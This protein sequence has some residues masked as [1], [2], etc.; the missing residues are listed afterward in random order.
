MKYKF[1]INYV[2]YE[3]QG[4]VEIKEIRFEK[5]EIVEIENDTVWGSE[6]RTVASVMV[7]KEIENDRR[8]LVA[9]PITV[10]MFCAEEIKETL[11]GKCK[12]FPCCEQIGTGYL[13]GKIISHC[14]IFEKKKLDKSK[15]I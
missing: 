13:I 10:L 15:K 14:G 2:C 3:K 1:K 5:G 7:S 6:D 8:E 4:L 12:K 9:I 11:C